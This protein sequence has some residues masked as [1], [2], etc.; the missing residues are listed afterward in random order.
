MLK[1]YMNIS[2]LFVFAECVR[3]CVCGALRSKTSIYLFYDRNL[4]RARKSHWIIL[5]TA[6]IVVIIFKIPAMRQLCMACGFIY[7]LSL[8][9]LLYSL[10]FIYILHSQNKKHISDDDKGKQEHFFCF[11]VHKTHV[12]IAWFGAANA[13]LIVDRNTLFSMTTFNGE[14]EKRIQ[15]VFLIIYCAVAP[16]LPP[17]SKIKAFT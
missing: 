2:R 14:R 16:S 17:R 7:K 9:F 13:N 10:D 4:I 11:R 5:I 1:L 3:V 15:S 12:C 6:E 8:F